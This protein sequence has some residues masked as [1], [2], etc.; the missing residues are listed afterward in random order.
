MQGLGGRTAGCQFAPRPHQSWVTLPGRTVFAPLGLSFLRNA[1][2]GPSAA[3]A[4]QALLPSRPRVCAVGRAPG[5]VGPCP[6]LPA[7]GEPRAPRGEAD[8]TCSAAEGP[9][10]R[11]HGERGSAPRPPRLRARDRTPSSA[12]PPASRLHLTGARGPGKG[13][14][15]PSAAGAAGL[16]PRAAALGFPGCPSFPTLVSRHPPTDPYSLGLH[17]CCACSTFSRSTAVLILFKALWI[18]RG[19]RPCSLAW[20]LEQRAN[21]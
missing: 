5:E 15:R 14:P 20:S 19:V 3:E 2:R 17:F 11:E 18:Q 12:P 4:P 9:A 16:L 13:K 1:G 6:P 8:L 7:A 21:T 10:E